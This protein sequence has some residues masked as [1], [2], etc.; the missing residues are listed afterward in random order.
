MPVDNPMSC[1]AVT[2]PPS[3]PMRMA[4]GISLTGGSEEKSP[5]QATHVVAESWKL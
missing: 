3:S 1:F 4:L 2:R 5:Y